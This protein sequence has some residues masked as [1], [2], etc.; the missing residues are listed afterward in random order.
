MC[1]LALIFTHSQSIK[2]L[3]TGRESFRESA[4]I[5]LFF[6]IY[7]VLYF[8]PI[9]SESTTNSFATICK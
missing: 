8:F 5:E 7:A 3:N 6:S 4:A 1:F 9:T 2:K